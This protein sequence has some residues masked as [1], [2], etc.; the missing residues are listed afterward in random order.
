G[1]AALLAGCGGG[2]CDLDADETLALAQRSGAAAI[3]P[4]YGYVAETSGFA[5]AVIEAGL[6][7]IGPPPAPIELLGDK[8]CARA[9]AEAVKAPVAPGSNGA[10]TD[11]AEAAK[12]AEGID[13]P[14]VVKA[15]HGGA[16]R[17]FRACACADTLEAA[18]TGAN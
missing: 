9:V 7:W 15:V 8:S 5:H 4:G 12:V 16:G 11:L 18:Y 14:V 6:T 10:V 2:E 13:L 17:C 3:H 1:G